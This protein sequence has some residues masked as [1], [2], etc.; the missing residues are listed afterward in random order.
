MKLTSK[1]ILLTILLVQ[2]TGHSNIKN[3]QSRQKTFAT[4]EK[5]IIYFIENLKQGNLDN[6]LQAC[7]VE[8]K[9]KNF[10]F[11]A[12]TK[13]LRAFIFYGWA[14]I[15]SE[16]EM[17]VQMNSQLSKALIYNQIKYLIYSLL[18][19]ESIDGRTIINPSDEQIKNFITD[20]NPRR[21]KNIEILKI[22]F[23]GLSIQHNER[24]LKN[25]KAQAKIYGAITATDRIVLYKFEGNYYIGGFYLL[26]YNNS[27]K[28]DSL[29]SPIGNTSAL[30]T[31]EKTSLEEFNDMISE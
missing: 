21:L 31:L 2:T 1:I 5:A 30:G 10:D 8:E 25:S 28:I 22:S 19:K 11:T 12:F 17:Y 13:R 27:W 29:N 18:S 3:I 23:P 24:Y 26:K 15:P 14:S 9:S 4:P 6:A 20:I 16:Y 7:S